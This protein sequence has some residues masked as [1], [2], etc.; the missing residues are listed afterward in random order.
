MPATPAAIKTFLS[1]PSFAVLGAV[2]DPSRYG[3]K[4]GSLPPQ[5]C[6]SV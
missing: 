1:T 3:H 4:G 5:G 6:P 2:P